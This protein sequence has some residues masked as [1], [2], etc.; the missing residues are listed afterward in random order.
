MD[1]NLRRECNNLKCR[2]NER[3]TCKNCNK[4]QEKEPQYKE[5]CFIR[6]FFITSHFL[7]KRFRQGK[8][9]R[10]CNANWYIKADVLCIF[11]LCKEISDNLHPQLSSKQKVMFLIWF[12][13][14]LSQWSTGW[15]T[16]MKMQKNLSSRTLH[17]ALQP[18]DSAP[19]FVLGSS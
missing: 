6:I 2:K 16:L 15:L 5:A 7:P 3:E 14:F 13:Q 19:K 4:G 17:L 1:E 18:T 11:N 8:G 10:K 12:K 9:E